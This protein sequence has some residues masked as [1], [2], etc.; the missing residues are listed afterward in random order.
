MKDFIE[1][2]E[3]TLDKNFNM[4]EPHNH[5][6]Y[7]FYFLLDGEREFFMTDKIINVGKN[8]LIIIPPFVLHKTEGGPY[9]RVNINISEK[10]LTKY[11]KNVVDGIIEKVLVQ[12]D[13]K[14]L[15]TIQH[16]L[17]EGAK[18]DASDDPNAIE[19]MT[20]FFHGIVK[21]L[22][23]SD[24]K[25]ADETRVLQI[26]D[27]TDTILKV[28]NYLNQHYTQKLNLKEIADAFYLSKTALCTSFN[29]VMNCSV[30]KYV[31]KLRIT[32][33]QKLLDDSDKSVEEIAEICGF[34]S[35][36]YFGLAFKNEKGK[37]PI[38][39]RKR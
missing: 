20:D 39:Y 16:L 24:L 6:C 23:L 15:P 1:F 9:R 35:A 3:L 21:L 13:E 4:T 37:S 26:S 12:L 29:K 30:M 14:H 19:F 2:S 36:S 32:A 11:E 5:D 22:G 17:H 25:S 28:V 33:A 27:G 34:S 10:Y 18:I 38:H 31:T 7:E 8:S